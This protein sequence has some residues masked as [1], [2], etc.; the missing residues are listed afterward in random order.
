MEA[1]WKTNEHSA[2]VITC[3]QLPIFNYKKP[4]WAQAKV[5]FF[6]LKKKKSNAEPVHQHLK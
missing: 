2:G 5:I 1:L 4:A 3:V 6:R